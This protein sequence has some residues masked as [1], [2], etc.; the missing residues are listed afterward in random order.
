MANVLNINYNTQKAQ[1]ILP[2][3][4]RNVQ[5]IIEYAKTI[6]DVAE[7]QATIEEVMKLMLQMTAPGKTMEEL[8][9]KLWK[10][11][12]QI[13]KYDLPGVVPVG[14]IPTPEKERSVPGPLGYPPQSTRYRHYGSHVQQLVRKAIELEDGPVKDG[15]VSAI[16]SYMKLAYKT[17]NKEHYV[18]DDIIKSDLLSLSEG[19]LSL[20]D[21]ASISNMN[22]RPEPRDNRDRR[23]SRDNRDRNRRPGNMNNNRPG[24]NN[25]NRYGNS[26]NRGNNPTK[27]FK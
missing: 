17:W 23:D 4:G 8:G 19:K 5:D 13:A 25:N 3:Y 7:K 22:Y 11:I 26:P 15:F 1:L 21:D 20:D 9:E 18:S 27:K 24:N 2:E 14:E 6:E 16:G 12:Y 10:H